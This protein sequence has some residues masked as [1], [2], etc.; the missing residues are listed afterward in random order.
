MVEHD[1][2]AADSDESTQG[3]RVV[4]ITVKNQIL[5]IWHIQRTR[6]VYKERDM[7]L[8]KQLRTRVINGQRQRYNVYRRQ[9]AHQEWGHYLIRRYQ[10]TR[11]VPWMP[12]FGLS[13]LIP[14]T[15]LAAGTANH[16]IMQAPIGLLILQSILI[17]IGGIMLVGSGWHI[18]RRL[19]SSTGFALETLGVSGHALG[20]PSGTVASDL[21]PAGFRAGRFKGAIEVEGAA[22]EWK[23]VA[24]HEADGEFHSHRAGF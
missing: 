12:S 21:V 8:P 20:F 6:T 7:E 24:E 19:Q 11:M 22:G 16:G 10:A 15:L 3:S 18:L 17:S 9:V 13:L 14:G 23:V 1:S 2:N 4:A 5:E